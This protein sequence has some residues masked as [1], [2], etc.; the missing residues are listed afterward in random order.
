MC[1][2]IL[3]FRFVFSC[4]HLSPVHLL[5]WPIYSGLLKCLSFIFWCCD[6]TMTRGH[7]CGCMF[8]SVH[9]H[10]ETRSSPFLAVL[11]EYLIWCSFSCFVSLRD[12]LGVF[13]EHLWLVQ[14]HIQ[15]TTQWIVSYLI[16]KCFW[17]LSAPCHGCLSSLVNKHT[18]ACM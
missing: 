16:A 12:W 15:T 8:P 9:M 17:V 18:C 10:E 13:N 7:V 5:W 2:G 6:K 11:A 1:C 3:F 4:T 14:I